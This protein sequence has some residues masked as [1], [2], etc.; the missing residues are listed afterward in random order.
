ML[1][2][3]GAWKR[4]SPTRAAFRSLPNPKKPVLRSVQDAIVSWS[5]EPARHPCGERSDGIRFGSHGHVKRMPLSMR[6]L[7]H[8]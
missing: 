4:Q 8:L 6:Y 1:L 7:S 2:L 3:L 5:V